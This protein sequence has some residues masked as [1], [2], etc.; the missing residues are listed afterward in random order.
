MV[1]PY[2]EERGLK[3]VAFEER[4]I[5][6]FAMNISAENL[7]EFEVV[8]E[9]S[10]V[11]ALEECI[12]NSLVF[13][14]EKD[15]EPL[16]VTGLEIQDDHALMWCMFS[17]NMRKNWISFARAS[18]KLMKFY[19]EMH[20]NLVADV[21][22][23]NS[24]IHQWLAYLKFTPVMLVELSNKQTVVRFVRCIPAKK[25]VVNK[26]LRPVLH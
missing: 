23:E 14:I 21:W 12:D 5:L 3:L 17:K 1:N 13:T 11:E 8:Y 19:E 6:P 7:R 25:S 20:P 24:M 26:T 4:H 16:A 18:E 15:G 22:I 9:T 10:I 2:I